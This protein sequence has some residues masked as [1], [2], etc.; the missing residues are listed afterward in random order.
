VPGLQSTRRGSD[1]AQWG[2]VP[3]PVEPPFRA[4]GDLGG[5]AEHNKPIEQP[6]RVFDGNAEQ[7]GE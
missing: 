4:V 6:D 5:N 3:K 7:F 2:E 1:L